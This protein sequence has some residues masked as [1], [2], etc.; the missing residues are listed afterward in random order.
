MSTFNVLLVHGGEPGLDKM[1]QKILDVLPELEDV[2]GIKSTDRSFLFE[3]LSEEGRVF[4]A[5][6]FTEEARM[7]Q[8]F[9][10][11]MMKAYKPREV[12]LVG[13][14][15]NDGISIADEQVFIVNDITDWKTN[16]YSL[17]N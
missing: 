17:K 15:K 12:V 3:R 4:D 10:L 11:R 9:F 1:K 2:K 14:R 13:D 8:W 16:L 6:I 7:K 5:I